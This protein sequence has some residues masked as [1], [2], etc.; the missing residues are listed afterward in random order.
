[1]MQE[2]IN[3]A[4]GHVVGNQ[5]RTL[6]VGLDRLAMEFD[7]IDKK[8][9]DVT[10]GVAFVHKKDRAVFSDAEVSRLWANAE[11]PWV[12][13]ILILLYSGWRVTELLKMRITDIDMANN[14]M[15]GGVKTAAGKDRIVPIHSATLPLIK[16]RYAGGINYI[17]EHKGRKV[18][19]ASYRERFID[20]MN[21]LGMNHTTRDTRRT[22]RTWLD[23]ASAPFAC[24][25]RIMGHTCKDIGLQVY[26]IKTVEEL[27]ATIELVKADSHKYGGGVNNT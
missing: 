22:L 9:S 4:V 21:R 8:Y 17:I 25:N 5:V 20:A 6:F 10:R 13:T 23:R 3:S 2:C 14:T 27:R 12:D 15:R 16:Q 18:S 7:I 24:A 11:E 26:T 19:Y 1:M